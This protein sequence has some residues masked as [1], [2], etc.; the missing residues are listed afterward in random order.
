M[1][2]IGKRRSTRRCRPTD[3][4]TI[5]SPVSANK[6]STPDRLLFLPQPEVHFSLISSLALL[7]RFQV[8]SVA[9][10]LIL[11]VHVDEHSKT[12]S[13]VAFGSKMDREGLWLV[14]DRDEG[15]DN[16]I[17]VDGA[18]FFEL[19]AAFGPFDLARYLSEAWHGGE[20]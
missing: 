3:V 7:R 12:L 17:A 2:V 6:S 18:I 4:V 19:E 8:E 16:A 10:A 15:L 13:Y 5:K 11:S 9:I 14:G 20:I 1:S